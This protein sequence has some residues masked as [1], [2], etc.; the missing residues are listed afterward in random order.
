MDIKIDNEY[1]IQSDERNIILVKTRKV[2]NGKNKGEIYEQNVSYHSTLQS[3]LKDYLRV[4][5]N[6]SEATSVQELL[7]EVEEI[8]KIIEDVLN[9]NTYK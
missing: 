6:L 8:K 4:K 2:E 3:A 7:K 1:S 5:T 9:L